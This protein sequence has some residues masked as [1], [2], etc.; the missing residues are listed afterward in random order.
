MY[1]QKSHFF[2]SFQHIFVAIWAVLFPSFP[3]V[4]ANSQYFAKKKMYFHRK[5]DKECDSLVLFVAGAVVVVVVQTLPKYVE[6]FLSVILTFRH[7][8]IVLC[9]TCLLYSHQIRFLKSFLKY[10]NCVCTINDWTGIKEWIFAMCVCVCFSLLCLS[11]LHK[12]SYKT[13]IY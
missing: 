9:A 6:N 7:I 11:S 13:N 3:S 1:I 2:I 10:K 4:R 12:L 5:M 8:P